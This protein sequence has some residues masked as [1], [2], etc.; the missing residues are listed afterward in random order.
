MTIEKPKYNEHAQAPGASGIK[1]LDMMKVEMVEMV[2]GA[3]VQFPIHDR[4]GLLKVFPK[5][6]PIS[7]SVGGKKWSMYDLI[8]HLNDSDFPIKSA[9]DLATMLTTRCYL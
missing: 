9:G 5:S 4:A 8:Q 6:T 7:C 2:T 3:G 1:D